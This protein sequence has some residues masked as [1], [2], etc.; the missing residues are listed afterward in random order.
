MWRYL[1]VAC[2]F[3]CSVRKWENREQKFSHLFLFYEMV[4]KKFLHHSCLSNCLVGASSGLGEEIADLFS[5]C[6]ASLALTGRNKEN[7]RK[8][9]EKCKESS[10]NK[11]EVGLMYKFYFHTN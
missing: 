8:V 4:L 6:G 11:L 5:K 7:L 3:R 10:P 1:V 2:K 9:A